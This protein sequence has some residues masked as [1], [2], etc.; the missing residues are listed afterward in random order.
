LVPGA[1]GT[2]G[3]GQNN[4]GSAGVAEYGRIIEP[5]FVACF[6]DIRC[7][8]A[9][10]GSAAVGIDAVFSNL[11]PLRDNHQRQ[12]PGIPVYQITAASIGYAFYAETP[13]GIGAVFV[14]ITS[15]TDNRRVVHIVVSQLKVDEARCM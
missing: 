10:H 14:K 12:C 9:G 11:R 1:F 5:V 6:H 8:D 2:V 15:A 4:H 7:P 3:S 13:G